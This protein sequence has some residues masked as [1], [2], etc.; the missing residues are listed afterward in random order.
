MAPS[1]SVLTELTVGKRCTAASQ[2]AG[3]ESPKALLFSGFLVA[4][5]V[6]SLNETILFAIVFMIFFFFLTE[7]SL[8]GGA[9][10]ILAKFKGRTLYDVEHDI[11]KLNADTFSCPMHKG[12]FTVLPSVIF[13]D[14]QYRLILSK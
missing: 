3:V 2:S 5:E 1:E 4:I 7:V 14:Q 12:I 11:C 6:A 8:H 9:V 13:F 10:H